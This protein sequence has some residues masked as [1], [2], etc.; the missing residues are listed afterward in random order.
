[1]S[2]PRPS[3]IASL[4]ALPR[5]A[6]VLFFGTFVN[7]VGTFVIPFLTLYLTQRGFSPAAAGFALGAYGAGNLVAGIIGGLLADRLGR[8]G[9]IVLSMFS[10]AAAMML[11]S[12]ARAYPL[13]VAFAALTGLTGEMYRPA[14]SALLADLVPAGQRVTAY[15]ALRASFNAGW[16]FGPALAGLIA[17]H[18]FFWLFAGDALTSA[19]YGMVAL[20][21][22]PAGVG[23]TAGRGGWGE[24]VCIMRADGRLLRM[25]AAVFAISLIFMQQTSTFGLHVVQLGFPAATYGLILSLNGAIIVCCELP[26]T[27]VTRRFPARPVIALGY[28]LVG[29]GFAANGLAHTVPALVAAMGVFTLGEMLAM[30]MASAYVADLAPVTMRGRYMGIYGMTWTFALIVGPA[31]G[32]TLMNAAPAALWSAAA[33]LGVLAAALILRPIRPAPAPAVQPGV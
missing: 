26:L 14:S 24:V 18:G 27:T 13:I 16:A 19:L 29:L 23:V 6:W 17:V 10:G 20:L 3:L 12:Q 30:P 15:S 4:R 22:L 8:R 25:L 7:K 2:P 9:T 33:G 21:A 32:M 31:A 1:M 5:A 11:L 28:F